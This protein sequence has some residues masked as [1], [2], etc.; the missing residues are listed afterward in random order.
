MSR[1]NPR[2][3]DPRV[4]RSRAAILEAALDELAERGYGA[5]A[6]DGVATRAGVARSTLYRLWSDRT[7][8][9]ADAMETLNVQPGPRPGEHGSPRECIRTLL[10]HLADAMD[11][12][13]MSACLPAVI[14]GAERDPALRD[15]HH[16][17]AA[18]RR[19]TLTDA[20][21]AARDAGDV[22][23]HVDPG[24]ASAAL[25]GAVFYRRLMTDRPLGAD[26]VDVLLQSVLGPGSSRGAVL[27]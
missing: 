18:R 13:R 15:L 8:L 16:G 26:E 25:A 22:G 14:D 24:L 7:S 10:L 2:A 3:E 9:V 12:T 27:Q 1:G 6:M 17:Y 19:A 23:P 4:R 20:I 21:A 11:G 5:F